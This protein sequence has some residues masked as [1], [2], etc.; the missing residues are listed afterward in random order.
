M[1]PREIPL[2][3][4]HILHVLSERSVDFVAIGG[5]AVQTHGH[6][7][8]TQDLDIVPE[9]SP[10]NRNRLSDALALDSTT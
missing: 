10:D 6:P 8:T 5:V 7:R 1:T 3:A 9:P 4:G 2:D